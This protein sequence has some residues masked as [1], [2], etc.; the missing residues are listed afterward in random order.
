V[1]VT[2]V[3][4]AGVQFVSAQSEQGTWSYDPAARQVTFSL[5]YLGLSSQ[6]SMSITVMPVASGTITNVTGVLIN[7]NAVNPSDSVVTEV[8]DVLEGPNL[9]PTLGIGLTPT[10]AYELRLTGAAEVQYDIQASADLISWNTITNALGPD[11]QTTISLNGS[12][13]S[14]RLFYR[15]EVAK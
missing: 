6:P 4:P 3:L 15:A 13:G 8:T 1:V 5:G 2:N 14:S 11:W 10:A 7:G 12:A 9:A